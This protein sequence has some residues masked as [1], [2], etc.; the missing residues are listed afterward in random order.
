MESAGST[1]KRACLRHAPM[2]EGPLRTLFRRECI[3]LTIVPLPLHRIYNYFSRTA[4]KVDDSLPFIIP[5]PS[6]TTFAAFLFVLGQCSTIME[7]WLRRKLRECRNTAYTA[8]VR[9]RGKPADWWTE[10]V[11]EWEEP[12]TQKAIKNSKK[13]AFYLKLATPLLRMVVLKGE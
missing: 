8:T 10:Y 2:P 3:L 4:D 5:L 1:G 11:E 6:L 12:P 7:F 9:S 13:Q